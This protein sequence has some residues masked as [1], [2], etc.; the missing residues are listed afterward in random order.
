MPAPITAIM[1]GTV[2]P[3]G[4]RIK[5]ICAG[6]LGAV[7][8]NVVPRTQVAC[9][10]SRVRI[11]AFRFNSTQGELPA[12]TWGG[13]RPYSR[14]GFVHERSAPAQGLR[15]GTSD[16]RMQNRPRRRSTTSPWCG[17]SWRR[18]AA[19]TKLPSCARCRA[20]LQM[21]APR[22]AAL[23]DQ[24]ASGLSEHR[25]APA[26]GVS[27]LRVQADDSWPKAVRST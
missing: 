14:R 24:A 17:A 3:G 4:S 21:V 18:R 11:L 20:R 27:G 6:F 5:P 13:Q 12:V 23:D 10:H 15:D 19:R 2:I 26:H 9:M 7:C 1:S 8:R 22:H 16:G 25:A